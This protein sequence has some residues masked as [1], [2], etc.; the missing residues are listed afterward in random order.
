[1]AEYMLSDMSDLEH[2]SVSP[3]VKKRKMKKVGLKKVAVNE[4][5]KPSVSICKRKAKP[6]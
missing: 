1:M 3:P 5:D 6:K 4:S 2:V